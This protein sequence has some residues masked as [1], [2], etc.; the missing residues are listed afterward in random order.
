MKN[1]WVWILYIY[2]KKNLQKLIIASI[3]ASVVT[4]SPIIN[5]DNYGSLHVVSI[6]HAEIQTYVGTGVCRFDFGE[7]DPDMIKKV[8]AV[9]QSRAIQAAK[10]QAGIYIR[11]YTKTMNSIITEDSISTM[12]NVIVDTVDTKYNKIPAEMD[13][14][15]GIRYEATVTVKIDTDGISNYLKLDSKNRI[16]LETQNKELQKAVVDSNKEI[17]T[18]EKNS[19]TT[20][21][22]EEKNKVKAEMDKAYNELLVNQKLDEGNKF[23]YQK[24]YHNAISKY[25]EAIEL[26]PNYAN[27]YY[28]RGN[29]Y[30]YLKNYEQAIE[31]YNKAIQLNPNYVAAY[32][33]RGL[34]YCYLKDYDKAIKDFN[35]TILLDPNYVAAYY[36]RGLSYCYLKDYDKAIKDFNKAIQINLNYAKAYYSRGLSYYYLKDY[37]KAIEDFTMYIQFVPNDIKGYNQRAKCYEQ[38][39]NRKSQRRL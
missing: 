21:T 25:N 9:A 27:T 15:I 8:Q 37:D 2:L 4:F 28:N 3:T 18:L 31:N 36:N 23:Y 33:N 34:S 6:T 14:D 24:D 12:T 22:T 38:I 20:K 7:N 17:E 32:Y 26:D 29:A 16:T 11:S 30:D 10:E 19:T 39:G 13:G 1:K 5:F 35:K